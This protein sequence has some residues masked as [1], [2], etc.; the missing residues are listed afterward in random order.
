MIVVRIVGMPPGSSVGSNPQ[1]C[2]D[3]KNAEVDHF[4]ADSGLSFAGQEPEV[5]FNGLDSKT[6]IPLKQ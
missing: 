6:S 5:A 1:T 4:L 3:V 2:E